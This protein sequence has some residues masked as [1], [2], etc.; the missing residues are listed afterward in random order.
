M[1]QK[2]GEDSVQCFYYEVQSFYYI[3][4]TEENNKYIFFLST[5]IA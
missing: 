2:V 1:L 4:T 3:S 5:E